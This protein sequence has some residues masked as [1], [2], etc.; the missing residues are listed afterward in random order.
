MSWALLGPIAATVLGLALLLWLWSLVRRDASVVDAWWGI[1]FLLAA[2]LAA[3]LAPGAPPRRALVL[4]LVAIWSLRLALHLAWR[5]Q[6]RGEDP[7]YAAMRRNHGERFGWVSLGTVFLLQGALAVAISL[8]LLVAVS[9]REPREL[10]LL[11][12]AG[13]LLWLVGFTFEAIGD[14]QLAR[15]RS[16]PGNRGKVLE[17]GLWRYTRHP[18][19]FGEALLWWG[20][21]LFA[22]ATP[23]AAWTLF[24]PALMTFLLLRVS[25]VSLLE[26]GLAASK[27]GWSD[28]ASRTSAF[29]PL[30]PRR[31]PRLK[32]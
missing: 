8:P 13:A 19:Y 18:N 26:T 24:A 17:R 30:P 3:V 20:Y 1:F 10:G 16:A 5:N 15:F 23:A 25:G 9:S 22:L 27:P 7:R 14:W 6:G 28:Y 32:E 4:A 12:L 31:V 2:S 21:G 29:L 11:D